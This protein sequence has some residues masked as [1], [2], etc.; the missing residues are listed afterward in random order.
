METRASTSPLN[1]QRCHF[2]QKPSSIMQ[3]RA[4]ILRGTFKEQRCRSLKTFLAKT[5]LIIIEIRVSIDVPQTNSVAIPESY[6]SKKKGP[7]DP[8]IT[9]IFHA[10]L[11][12]NKKKQK[13]NGH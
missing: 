2:R 7:F 1:E 12:F 4:F 8:I 9:F 10:F 13:R 6:S 11:F 5:E 3:M